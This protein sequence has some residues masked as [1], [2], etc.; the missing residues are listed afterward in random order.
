MG[1]RTSFFLWPVL[2]LLV[3]ALSACGEGEAQPEATFDYAPLVQNV[4]YF[5]DADSGGFTG[6]R[7]FNPEISTQDTY[8]S[9]LCLAQLGETLSPGQRERLLD[10]LRNLP[11][12]PAMQ[13]LRAI[14]NWT[15]SA[16]Y[17]YLG[18][19]QLLGEE[20][21][22]DALET[23]LSTVAGL[24][25]GG[26]FFYPSR[27]DQEHFPQSPQ[28]LS[29][30]NQF[31]TRCAVALLGRYDYPFH[32]EAALSWYERLVT[33]PPA[34]GKDDLACLAD[35]LDAC[36][37]LG[38][39][40]K[41]EIHDQVPD[42]CRAYMEALAHWPQED[43]ADDS[44]QIFYF[45]S[46]AAMLHYISAQ[47]CE[48]SPDYR[49]IGDNLR[50]YTYADGIFYV[51]PICEYGSNTVAA[52]TSL[53]PLAEMETDS[54]VA[55]AILAN[56]R[57]GENY[58]GTFL[59]SSSSSI[60]LSDAYEAGLVLQLDGSAIPEAQ[61][62]RFQDYLRAQLALLQGDAPIRGLQLLWLCRT[63]GVEIAEKEVNAF[64]NRCP[65]LLEQAGYLAMVDCEA[66]LFYAQVC[67][68]YGFPMDPD[69]RQQI[70]ETKV[71]QDLEIPLSQEE[72]II[73]ACQQLQLAYWFDKP[74]SRRQLRQMISSYTDHYGSV[75][76]H[77]LIA[78]WV[79]ST[80]DQYA[81]EGYPV[82]PLPESIRDD[83]Q[84]R[85]DAGYDGYFYRVVPED[86]PG[87]LP[88][89]YSCVVQA[90]LIPY[91]EETSRID[92]PSARI[93]PIRTDEIH[94]QTNHAST[95]EGLSLRK[96]LLF[97]NM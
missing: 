43:T 54:L 85:L 86:L 95:Q 4:L 96:A 76:S 33:A 27:Y 68:D 84:Q 61:R 14:D 36:A 38:R 35:Y 74:A 60:E 20:P 73:A 91:A 16:I 6:V 11:N 56:I 82:P 51:S 23:C 26:G 22:P 21:D 50:Q 90:G 7:W 12:D 70:R 59:L 39:E 32:E 19:F 10:T 81:R 5:Q 93:Q 97:R 89:Y 87:L 48:V 49:Q 3:F 66:I 34:E 1:N 69:W 31:Y 46:L 65:D 77:L 8:Y 24:Q 42:D 28:E 72:Q 52:S 13:E 41:I 53:L 67:A 80:L 62:K 83:M 37:A 25:N 94:P 63:F 75:E 64:L 17:H 57:A 79:V 29:P 44:T 78:Y 58:D 15:I 40:P 2:L 9:L 71:Q 18:I 45:P 92:L 88:T 30:K 55:D 47:G